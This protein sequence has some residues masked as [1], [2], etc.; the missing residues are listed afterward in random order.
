[1][2]PTGQRVKTAKRTP[3]RSRRMVN[4]MKRRVPIF[5][6]KWSGPLVRK[7]V[8]STRTHSGP[9]GLS[10]SKT[11]RA[12]GRAYAA[13]N[14]VGTVGELAEMAMVEEPGLFLPEGTRL[15]LS[16]FGFGDLIKR[17]TGYTVEKAAGNVIYRDSSGKVVNKQE[18]E[19]ARM[20][21]PGLGPA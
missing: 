4:S 13:V 18:V 1:M 11:L 21:G 10:G 6:K 14:L 16:T 15:E 3:K 17:P 2:L 7:L 8:R 19:R 5:A 12:V 9:Q 20:R